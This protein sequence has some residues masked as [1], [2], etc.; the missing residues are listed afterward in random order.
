M[1]KLPVE[2][3]VHHI[4]PSLDIPS[5]NSFR[6]TSYGANELV[7]RNWSFLVPRLYEYVNKS[8]EVSP[9]SILLHPLILL[10][11]LDEIGFLFTDTIIVTY[12]GYMRRRDGVLIQENGFSSSNNQLLRNKDDLFLEGPIY[13]SISGLSNELTIIVQGTFKH[14]RLDGIRTYKRIQGGVTNLL[15][16][17]RYV[18]GSID[19]DE[20]I[21]NIATGQLSILEYSDDLPFKE[22][23]MSLSSKTLD[24][25]E[26]DYPSL[27]PITTDTFNRFIEEIKQESNLFIELV[28]WLGYYKVIFRK[29]IDGDKWLLSEIYGSVKI[30]NI[31]K[32]FSKAINCLNCVTDTVEG[33]TF[34]FQYNRGQ[35]KYL[36]IK[37]DPP[38]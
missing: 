24:D 26:I 2:L 10:L 36:I 33:Y 37:I 38:M 14:N 27:F 23:K 31:T 9:S 29:D 3:L 21:F 22:M 30:N 13:L 15:T 17:R 35:Q 8:E 18:N 5:I 20:L 6:Q 34:Y 4:L 7:E 25:P 32:Y 28:Y 16:V 11:D 19:R 1:D 12:R